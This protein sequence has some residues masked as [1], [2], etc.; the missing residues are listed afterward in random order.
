MPQKLASGEEPA[1]LTREQRL[2]QLELRGEG[3][4]SNE[5][6]A[7][8]P[9]PAQGQDAVTGEGPV[10]DVLGDNTTNAVILVMALIAW[11]A[12]YAV[13]NRCTC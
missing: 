5:D 10:I 11:V 12:Q 2:R 8:D 6:R 9:A 7:A 3:E 1:V 13:V 4:Q